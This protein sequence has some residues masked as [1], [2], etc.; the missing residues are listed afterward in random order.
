MR[1]ILL[2][3]IM[4]ILVCSAL[5]VNASRVTF[6]RRVR[7]ASRRARVVS[8]DDCFV[9]PVTVDTNSPRS[10]LYC[11]HNPESIVRAT[12]CWT[13]VA[14]QKIRESVGDFSDLAVRDTEFM[15][16]T[17]IHVAHDTPRYT[18]TYEPKEI[19]CDE[20]GCC[21]CFFSCCSCCISLSDAE[22]KPKHD[23]SAVRCAGSSLLG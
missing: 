15:P 9:S 17:I 20:V 2:H 12:Q 3:T 7:H 4:I 23:K 8:S 16:T 5:C 14:A 10:D 19:E 22:S 6:P 1:L 18:T 11:F 13:T 21:C